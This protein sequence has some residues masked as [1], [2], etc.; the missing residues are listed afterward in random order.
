[1][2]IFV[3]FSAFLF[4]GCYSF[5]QGYGQVSLFLK[6]KPIETVIQENKESKD[7]IDKLKLVKPVLEYAKSEIGLT[8]GKSYKKYI[9]LDSPYVSWIVQASDKRS[10]KLKTWWFPIVG[11]QPYLGF[12]DKDKAL[13]QR[14]LLISE[15]YDTVTGGVSAFSLL[16]Y[17]PDPLYSSMLDQYSITEFIETL[18]HESVHRTIYVPNYYSFNENLADFIAKRATTQFLKLHPE[19]NQDSNKYIEEYKKHR[20]AQ[21]KF[22]EYLLKVREELNN[23]YNIA[24]NNDEFKNES[25][26]LSEREI[27]FNQISKDYKTFMNGVD[28]G[29][30]YEYSFQKG[31]INNAVILGYSIYEAKQ[32]PLE[33]ALQNAGGN[34]KQMLKNL[35]VCLSKSPQDEA[36]LWQKV[37]GCLISKEQT[38]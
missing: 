3:F 22:Q 36:D 25:I 1:M 16:G 11:K 21:K 13:K 31:K 20:E 28:I 34:L 10:L 18:I 2:K 8:P 19:L 35:E 9:S 29:T 30:S 4:S 17:F 15:G 5:E 27:K 24:Q 26:F 38:K 23:F 14:E 32:E 12:F 37:E 6:Q 33:K 7:R